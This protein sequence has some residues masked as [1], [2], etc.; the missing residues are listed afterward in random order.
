[1]GHHG[2]ESKGAGLMLVVPINE[3]EAIIE[4]FWDGGSSE[5]PADKWA[6]LTEYTTQVARS[7]RGRIEQSWCSAVVHIDTAPP[8]V[9]A[10]SMMRD[11]D[12]RLAGYDVFRIFAS[13]PSWVRLTA[14]ATIDGQA[15]V[16]LDQVAGGDTHDEFDGPISGEHMTRLTL[17]FSLSED[18]PAYVELLW[19][20]LANR[21]AQTHMEARR[22]PYTPEWRGALAPGT[23]RPQPQIGIFFDAHE[24]SALRRKVQH[25]ALKAIY[26]RV[27]RQAEQD[28]QAYRNPEEDIG[29]FVPNPDRRWC[30]NRDMQRRRTAG[31]MERLAFVGLVDGNADMSV[32]AARMALSAA[33]CDTWCESIMGVFPGATWHHR[34]FTEEVYCR[35]CALVLDWA[36]FC[37]TSHGKQLIRDAIIMKGLP[38]IESDFK[39]MEYIRHMNQGIV[40]SAGRIIGLLGLLPAHP[41]YAELVDEAERDLREMLDSY[42]QPDGGTL[43]G[44]AYWNYTFG[45]VMPLYLALAR[46]HGAKDLSAFRVQGGLPESLIKTG[47]YA[48]SMLSTVGDGTTYLPINDAHADER[49]SPAL[50]AAYCQVSDRSEWQ[51]LYAATSGAGGTGEDMYHIIF[52]PARLAKA[53]PLVK[54]RFD[55]LPDVG[56]VSSVRA[57]PQL[58]FVHFHLSA[59]PILLTHYH[60]DRGSFVLEAAGEAL[61]IDRG[62]TTYDHP[63]VGLIGAAARHNLLYPESPDGRQI[64][65]PPN[66]YGATLNSAVAEGDILLLAADTTQSWESGVYQAIR[67]RVVSPAPALYLLD[68]EAQ[69]VTPMAVSFRLNTRGVIQ[70][71]GG[72]FW[73]T[74]ER[75][76]LRIVPLNW[77]PAT[78]SAG[79]EGIDSHLQPVNVLRIISAKA[80]AHRL[81][82]AIEVLPAGEPRVAWQFTTGK[83]ITATCQGKQVRLSVGRRPSLQVSVTDAAGQVMAA[84]CQNN[85]W[86]L[87]A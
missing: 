30:R 14:R 71:Q 50:I 38:R 44:M 33:H 39:R 52:A 65:Q 17:E 79:V 41:R 86:E 76:A 36:G 74:S 2:A 21:A 25:G 47:D 5:H 61:A 78:F 81:V 62:V 57:H 75:A 9:V 27:R 37:L 56:E 55:A 54:P 48:L 70:T 6:A 63:E 3:A 51:Q 32:L 64:G 22:S 10:A 8:G 11:C 42:V 7:A 46:Y 85:Q 72:E 31:V 82:T 12:V 16:L 49:I 80:A 87:D 13:L 24:L 53:A 69:M 19:L 40:F 18:R 1:M 43:E 59:G 73:V 4:P 68:D 77:Q 20:G 26:E 28:M 84:R 45:T 29:Y 60:M 15:C 66:A 23:A 83:V 58:G 34:S 35:A 67:R